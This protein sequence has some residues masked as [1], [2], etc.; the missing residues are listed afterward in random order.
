MYVP[1]ELGFFAKKVAPS[2]HLT[3]QQQYRKIF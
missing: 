3:K 1:A 2:E